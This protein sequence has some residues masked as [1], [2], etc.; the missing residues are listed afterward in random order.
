MKKIVNAKI[1]K[2]FLGQFVGLRFSKR[3]NLIFKLN[4]EKVVTMD[5][6]FVFYPIDLIF[7]N[8]NKVVIELKSNFKPFTFYTSKNKVDYIIELKNGAI[9]EL[10]LKLGDK[11]EF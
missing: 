10:K 11:L 5:M 6:F 7:L 8:K 3:K 2:S 9:K 4:K 1:V